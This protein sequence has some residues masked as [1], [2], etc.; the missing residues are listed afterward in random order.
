MLSKVATKKP[1]ESKPSTDADRIVQSVMTKTARMK[2]AREAKAHEQR[3]ART[4]ARNTMN[5]LHREQ[6]KK[7]EKSSDAAAIRETKKEVERDDATRRQQKTDDIED[8][9]RDIEAKNTPTPSQ[10]ATPRRR[11]K[12]FV[13]FDPQLWSL[14]AP[15]NQ[16]R[17]PFLPSYSVRPQDNTLE[18]AANADFHESAINSKKSKKAKTIWIANQKKQKNVAAR[19]RH[20]QAV[21]KTRRKAEREKKKTEFELVK[22]ERR[23]RKKL[24]VMKDMNVIPSD[25][26]LKLHL[27]E[28]KK[29]IEKL[30]E[31]SL[32]TIRIE[33]RVDNSKFCWNTQYS[34]IRRSEFNIQKFFEKNLIYE[35]LVQN[36]DELSWINNSILILVRS[37]SRSSWTKQSMKDFSETEWDDVTV[38][39][40]KL[41]K[42]TM[43]KTK[44]RSETPPEIEIL[45]N[46][47]YKADPL[48]VLAKK[49]V[50]NEKLKAI[51]ST[52]KRTTETIVDSIDD[53]STSKKHTR[54]DQLKLEKKQQTPLQLKEK[55]LVNKWQCKNERC[56]NFETWCWMNKKERHYSMNSDQ[57]N[58]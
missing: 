4:R 44:K 1:A 3:A 50:K 47:R 13:P 30:I 5:N 43:A 53:T 8:E 23:R 9:R 28:E 34:N 18:T 25:E 41:T 27:D 38:I 31:N 14:R 39:A 58:R 52:L 35:I 6:E 10:L 55:K 26:L 20:R 15:Q 2:R 54:I 37:Q 17:K 16:R 40:N 36:D 32:M 42:I 7:K 11:K 46:I 29:K 33:L 57:M 19:V 22:T 48:K 45:L 51:K 56:R 12:S 21:K 49:Q 24:L